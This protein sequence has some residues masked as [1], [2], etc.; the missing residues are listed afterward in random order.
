MVVAIGI[1]SISFNFPNS[2]GMDF[3]WHHDGLSTQVQVQSIIDGG[4]FFETS[5]LG[6]PY[7]FSHWTVPQFGFFHVL[8][9]WIIGNVFPISVFGLM[10]VYACVTIFLNG[11]SVYFVLYKISNNPQ[12]SLILGTITSLV[13]YS[14]NQLA[15]P[16]VMAFYFFPVAVYFLVKQSSLHKLT[17]KLYFVLTISYISISI[18]WSFVMTYILIVL[19]VLILL[20]R[21]LKIPT[22]KNYL[23]AIIY[24][25]SAA[26]IGI[27]SNIVLFFLNSH[28]RGVEDRYPWQ[29]DI[30]AGKL[31]DILV[32]SPFLNS[33][34]PR[35]NTFTGGASFE[36]S[37]LK[38]GVVFGI[39]FMLAILFIFVSLISHEIPDEIKL[40]SLLTLI[41]F[42]FYVVGGLSNLQ[43]GFFNFFE[44]V[45]P[46]RS[47]ARLSILISLSGLFMLSYLVGRKNITKIISWVSII[48]VVFALLDFRFNKYPDFPE[49]NFSAQ[50]E[51]K[52]VNY[53]SQNLSPCAVLQLP[54]DTYVLP[55]GWLDNA[56]RYYWSQLKPYIMLKSFYWTGGTYTDSLGWRNLENVPTN[57]T[58]ENISELGKA[59]CAILFDK[60]FSSYQIDRKASLSTSELKW[61]GLTISER[62]KP[63]YEDKRF[64]IYRLQK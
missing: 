1:V 36:S 54:V 49:N 51:F 29:S 26:L 33:K 53:L 22:G 5:H 63:S 6:F 37:H 32:G 24:S 60:D 57:I 52:A 48:G 46:M 31:S 55:Q 58:D 47:W 59:Y 10:T 21:F 61:P 35:L 25:L 50:E 38:L 12:F 64:Q 39:L 56:D 27:I 44:I 42:L 19:L 30:F 4:P 45:S 23:K 18:F 3:I 41:L 13:P 34:F 7:G 20:Q 16:H 9:I 28:L 62:I 43:A 14:V 2:L 15:R 11:A 8:Y 17:Y 40:I